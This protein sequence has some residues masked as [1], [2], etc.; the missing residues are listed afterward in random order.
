MREW[1]L[2]SYC[3]VSLVVLLGGS[4]PADAQQATVIGPIPTDSLNEVLSEVTYWSGNPGVGDV[5]SALTGLEVATAPLGSPSGGFVYSYDEG[6]GAPLRRSGTFG[7]QFVERALT[8]GRG[9]T[10]FGLNVFNATYDTLSGY[11]LDD[12]R[13]A[14]FRGPQPLISSSTL[15]LRLQSQT[16]ALFSSVGVTDNLDV[17]V[18]VPIV[19]VAVDATLMQEEPAVGT[20]MLL[21]GGSSTGLGDIAVVGKYRF[22]KSNDERSGLAGLV[23]LRMPTGDEDNLRGL[24]AWRTLVSAIASAAR[25]RVAVHANVGYEFWDRSVTLS[26]NQPGPFD[27]VWELADQMQYG[28]AVEFEVRPTLT[29]MVEAMGRI[30]RNSGQLETVSFDTEY[31]PELGSDGVNLLQVTSGR[32]RKFVMVPGVK[33]NL[34]GNRLFSFGLRI[35]QGD[36]GLR[37]TLTPLVG[38]NWTL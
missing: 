24:S 22:W 10:S 4:W 34:G 8:T 29:F 36:T 31:S 6:V 2:S 19:R 9:T 37:D 11:P 18:A 20:A 35:A 33:W 28:M 5:I 27:Q 32:L 12:L 16:M 15:K 30:V 13:V 7:P 1:R 14:T 21:A 25:G 26:N 23:T 17:A 3:I 38:F